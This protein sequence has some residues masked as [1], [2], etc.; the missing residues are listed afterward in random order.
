MNYQKFEA[1]ITKLEQ[2][3]TLNP[4]AYMIKVLLVAA[5]GFAVL[6]AAVLFAIFP[7]AILIG[8]G[9]LVVATGGK[10]LLLV[11]KFGKLLFLMLVPC[12]VMLKASFQMLFSRFPAPQ[13]R[14]LAKDEAPDLFA[15]IAELRQRTGGPAIHHVLLT[16]E[17]NAAIV[18]HPRFGLLGWEQNYL[19]LGLPL[20]QLLSEEEALAVIAHEYGHLS[21]H[22][23]R[24]GGFIY[25]FR[26]TWGQ[27]QEL[28]QQWEDWGSRLITRLF[29]TYAPYFN[30]Y[31]FVYARHNEYIAD[32][33]S[34]ELVGADAT[35]HALIRTQIAAEFQQKEFWPGIQKLAGQQ[36]NP[37]D[38]LSSFWRDSLT[39]KLDEEKRN[40]YFAQ[41]RQLKT[42]HFDTHPALVDRLNAIGFIPD[43]QLAVS[44]LPQQQAASDIWLQSSL[45]KIAS[46]FD[47]AWQRDIAENWEAQHKHTQEQHQKLAELRSKQDPDRDD[48]WQLLVLEN[49]LDS[50]LDK[51]ALFIAFAD[52]FPEHISARYRRGLIL[53]EQKNERGAADLDYVMEKD[54]E[55]IPSACEILIGFYQGKSD[56]KVEFY[57]QKWI[58]YY[59][60]TQNINKEFSSLPANATL[61]SHD[62]DEHEIEKVK[63]LLA[64]NL[65]HIKNLY[66]LKR[67]SKH[68]P[69]LHDYV[70]AVEISRWTLG[71]K[72]NQVL[73][74]LSKVELPFSAF[75]VNLNNSTYKSFRKTITLLSIK[76][77]FEQ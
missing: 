63:A 28:S 72:S 59:E 8:L 68:N 48:R 64:P 56:E 62:L 26:S 17:L 35:A 2:E 47:S 32:S 46:E 3:A 25:R 44:L 40:H 42:D 67:P 6:G 61:I 16:N 54:E 38:N 20:L 55:A 71:D 77:L 10:A 50:E 37:L 53:L 51:S 4:R 69:K 73:Q 75:I 23:S 74:R 5:L 21:G 70:V 58:N 13:G 43:E 65:E 19:I 29:S 52:E 22:H 66:L 41:A 34:V 9:F 11:A 39:Q 18:Q 57:R 30:A 33:L 76:P 60:L 45:T 36:A 12:W 15:R 31:T 24:L 14:K 7:L 49:E 1:L 27:L